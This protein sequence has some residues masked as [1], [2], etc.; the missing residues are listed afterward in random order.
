MNAIC[1]SL[2]LLTLLPSVAIAGEIYGSLTEAEKS[3][4]E[5][6]RV[7]IRC[8]EKSYPAA[9]TDKYG[10]YRLYVQETGKCTL[11][12][13]YKQQSP[14]IEISSYE[15]SVRYDLVLQK[16]DGQYALRRQ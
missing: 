8:G 2:L 16:Q 15:R 5:G 10:S 3:V 12:V 13:R 7:E 14:A 11:K 9:A 4:G 6:V 1:V